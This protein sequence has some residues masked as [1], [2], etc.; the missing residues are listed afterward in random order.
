M[1]G[2]LFRAAFAFAALLTICMWVVVL[3]GVLHG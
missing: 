1:I 2:V 3:A